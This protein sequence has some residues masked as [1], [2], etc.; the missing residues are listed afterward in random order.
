MRIDPSPTAELCIISTS[1]WR[2]K[3]MMMTHQKQVFE[4]ILFLYL[5]KVFFFLYQEKFNLSK[6]INALNDVFCSFFS[7]PAGLHSLRKKG[8]GGIGKFESC[9]FGVLT[10]SV[11]PVKSCQMSIKVASKMI[12]ARKMKDFNNF[13]KLPKNV[14]S[15]GKTIV[16]A[17]F[18]KLSKGQ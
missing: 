7:R 8:I 1:R 16:V 5:P 4:A 2:Q 9:E 14:S 12:A 13:K 17:G 6:S 11:W 15:L 18:E 3:K 10:R